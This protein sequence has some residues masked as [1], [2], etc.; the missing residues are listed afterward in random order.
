MARGAFGGTCDLFAPDVQR[1]RMVMGQM[2]L[3]SA[4]GMQALD[5][6]AKDG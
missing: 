4:K 5:A 6:L 1:I 2:A 3:R